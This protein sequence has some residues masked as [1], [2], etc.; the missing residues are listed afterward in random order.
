MA[1][2]DFLNDGKAVTTPY[3]STSQTA[4]P[5]W[6][7]NYAMQVLANQQAVSNTPYTT[8]QGPRVAGFNADDRNA[9]SLTRDATT[10]YQGALGAAGQAI[11]EVNP[12]GALSAATPY[13]QQA[14]GR[15]ADHASEY[16][17]PFNDLV[18][19]RIGELG[20]RNLMEKILPQINDT[21]I[22]AG[23][24]GGSRQAEVS[25]RAI[26]D[27]Q[28]EI[29]AQQAQALAQGYGQAAD[30]YG[31]DAARASGVGGQFAS[32]IGQGNNTSLAKAGALGSLASQT[33]NQG[34]TGAGALGSVGAQERGMVQQNYDT[35]YADFLRQQ[36]YPQE[37]IDAM[38]KTLGG[39]QP[40]VPKAIVEAGIKPT[41]DF[42]PS[43]AA[44]I[45]S[46]ASLAKGLGLF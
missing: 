28:S 27:A 30:I 46:I 1:F 38:T 42:T 19:N 43:T 32:I 4:L 25:G 8:F 5:D 41:G 15:F 12:G 7:S 17:S 6:Y 10:G 29:S 13:L 45:G 23:S 16:M 40:A 14:G 20:N 9:F 2:L 31:A 22:G 33:Q 26:R 36:G 11:G 39:V 37:Q 18:V 21:F 34:L 24:F 3:N 35:A 44:S